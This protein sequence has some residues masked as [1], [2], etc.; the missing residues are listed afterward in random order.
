VTV[1]LAVSLLGLG[2]TGSSLDTN[3]TDVVVSPD[4]ETAESDA[5][6]VSGLEITDQDGTFTGPDATWGACE[7][8]GGPGCPCEEND[9]CYSGYCVTTGDGGLCTKACEAD[10]PN[11][12]ACKDVATGGSDLT[13][14]CVPLYTNLCR[15]CETGADCEQLGGVGGYCLPGAAGSF[16]GGDCDEDTPCPDGFQCDEIILSDALTVSQC[17]PMNGQCE[18]NSLAVKEGASTTCERT[19][20]HGSCPGG[21]TCGASGLE[22][23]DAAEPAAELCDGQDNDCD[24]SLDEVGVTD[25]VITNEHGTCQGSQACEDGALTTCTAKTPTAEICDGVDDNCDGQTDEGFTDTDSDGEPDCTD[26]DDDGDGTPDIEDCLP[27]DDGVFPG[28]FDTCNLINEDCD[29]ETDEDCGYQSYSG[30][31]GAGFLAAG[32]SDTH[33]IHHELGLRWATGASSSETHTLQMF[34]PTPVGNNG[35][36]P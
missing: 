7:N 11:G 23:C 4:A 32:S 27:L 29:D 24:G 36:A 9:D 35:G 21:A 16:C 3:A 33:V 25:C 26:E 14:I 18:C 17:V 15:P 1:L 20:E 31:F 2:C 34:A 5:I 12:W 13:Y 10:C 19:N 30:T 6:D 28:A 8:A 22:V